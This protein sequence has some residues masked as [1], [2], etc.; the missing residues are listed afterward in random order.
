[1]T[2]YSEGTHMPLRRSTDVDAAN[3][4][5]QSL[6]DRWVSEAHILRTRYA[7][8]RL[9]ALTEAHASELADALKQRDAEALCLADAS[10]ESGYSIPHLRHLIST[11]EIPN[12]GRRGRPRIS[13]GSLPQKQSPQYVAE[14]SR[15]GGA[16]VASL[17]A[18]ALR[19][20]AT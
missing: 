17:V 16:D 4:G 12:V 13:R 19:R 20:C 7:D 10:R 3:A 18:H 6:I 2:V 11:G 9:A 5:L 15:S 14:R 1:M 8:Q